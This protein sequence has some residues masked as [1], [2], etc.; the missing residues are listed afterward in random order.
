M[1]IRHLRVGNSASAVDAQQV[2]K[3]TFNALRF[4]A[5]L[6]VLILTDIRYQSVLEHALSKV[7]LSVVTGIYMLP[8]NLNL[9]MGKTAI[10]F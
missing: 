4:K 2:L 3:S 7:D 6:I 10:K 9:S 1:S 5:I 8:I